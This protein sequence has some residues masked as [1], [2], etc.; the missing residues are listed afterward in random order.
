MT[1]QFKIKLKDSSK[2]PIWRKLLVPADL[3]FYEFHIAIQVA[4]GWYNAHLYEF[5]E[6]RGGM[7]IVDDV[8]QEWE[9]SAATKQSD[10]VLLK[11]IFKQP[12][13]SLLYLYDFGDYWQH[14]IV[15]E[16][17]H[18]E[19]LPLPKVLD[20]KGTCPP[21]DCG[22]IHG[23]Y[24]MVRQLSAPSSNPDVDYREWL[25]LEEGEEWELDAFDLAKA[26][27]NMILTFT[28]GAS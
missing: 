5:T 11:R 23:Y 9:R 14:E 27:Q 8:A 28:E 22:G 15:L 12:K 26:N 7:R 25:G 4:F 17:I 24:E 20:G 16:K 3:T 21:E 18:R 19:V 6:G 10:K 2:P 13:Q 1:L